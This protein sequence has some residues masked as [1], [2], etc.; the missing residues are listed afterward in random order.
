MNSAE[1]YFKIKNNYR[2]I[3]VSNTG[4]ISAKTLLSSFPC[5][6]Y[7]LLENYLPIKKDEIV[8]VLKS[9]ATE[10]KNIFSRIIACYKD[11]EITEKTKITKIWFFLEDLIKFNAD[12][13]YKE[14]DLINKILKTTGSCHEIYHCELVP[15]F[16]YF[17]WYVSEQITGLFPSKKQK[18][19]LEFSNK[20]CCL[21]N[22][23][24]QRRYILSSWLAT[25]SQVDCSQYHNIPYQEMLSWNILPKKYHEEIIEGAK[26]LSNMDL[27][28]LLPLDYISDLAVDSLIC[29]TKDSFCSVVTESRYDTP[30]PN[31]SEKTVRVIASGR[32][33]ILL[34]P[35]GTLKLLKALG[36]KT[37]SEYW[38]E[39]YDLVD[40]PKERLSMVMN[41]IAMILHRTDH[42]KMLENMIPILDH[43]QEALADIPKKMLSI[44]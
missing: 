24:D 39:N 41:Q 9:H 33:F 12:G 34:A 37:F 15:N 6:T 42:R 8:L 3:S 22:R 13:S 21:N 32:P 31:F 2:C 7:E 36:I 40:D 28:H 43:N 35:S 4:S 10:N 14:V 5:K 38:D 30:W 26:I 19:S 27:R 20:I 44:S 1:I 23:F 25:K 16:N 17:D 18:I 29:R 11:L